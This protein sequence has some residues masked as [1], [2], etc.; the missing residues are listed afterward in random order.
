MKSSDT[1]C[2]MLKDN[3]YSAEAIEEL[4]QE[5][6]HTS[7]E[8][9]DRVVHFRETADGGIKIDVDDNSYEGVGDIAEADVRVF[10]QATIREWEQRQGR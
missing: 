2:K 6:L 9:P 5:R 7:G 3:G 4:L 10:V 1:F 8:L